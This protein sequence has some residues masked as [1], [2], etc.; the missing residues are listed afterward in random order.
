MYIDDPNQP[1]L[2]EAMV[3]CLLDPVIGERD[4]F[5]LKLADTV[6]LNQCNVPGLPSTLSSLSVRATNGHFLVS[7]INVVPEPATLT[8]FGA[9]LA[10]LVWAGRRGR[11][12]DY[13]APRDT[14]ITR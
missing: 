8:L 14:A 6:A 13:A 7:R 3:L 5:F 4:T 9:G 11:A 10:G 2:T 12:R 1:L